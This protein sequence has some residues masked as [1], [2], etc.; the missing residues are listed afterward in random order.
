[1]HAFIYLRSS[2]WYL[3]DGHPSDPP[4]SPGGGAE[5]ESEANFSPDDTPW[6][7]ALSE[8]PQPSTRFEASPTP[9]PLTSKEPVYSFLCW[10]VP[11]L[12][13]PAMPLWMS[14]PF[15]LPPPCR[16]PCVAQGQDASHVG[17]S[18]TAPDGGCQPWGQ[19][20][21]GGG[22]RHPRVFVYNSLSKIAN[23]C[24]SVPVY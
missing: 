23:F 12:P 8:H 17:P 15:P 4:P 18:K 14:T 2:A 6:P 22:H 9:K 3:G 24:H 11:R 1:M 21:G 10:S 5:R 13:A 7:S 20:E 19:V 16:L